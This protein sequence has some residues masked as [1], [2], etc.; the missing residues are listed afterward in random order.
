MR[1]IGLFVGLCLVVSTG[2][3]AAEEPEKT[4]SALLDAITKGT[5][6]LNL[7]Y[8]FEDVDQDGFDQRGKASTLR[9]MA[10]YN[11]GTWKG[12]EI[13][14]E[15]EDVH[16]LGLS[17]DH[18]NA[19]AG[20]LW[21]GV[22]DR[23]VIPDPAITEINQAYLG[24]SPVNTLPLRFGLQEIVV[25]NSRFIGNVG[26]RQNHQ[27]FE[28]ARAAFNGV[29]NLKLDF[30]YIGRQHNIFGGSQPMDTMHLGAAYT[31]GAIGT[32]KAYW[33]ILDYDREQLQALNN[34][35]IGAFFD[36]N[37]KLGKKLKLGYRLEY[38]KQSD[39]NNPN[40]IDADYIRADL[41]LTVSKVVF[42]LGYEALSGSEQDGQFKTPLATLH[43]FN[44]WADKF[45]NTPTNGLQDLFASVTA[46]LGKFKLEGIYHDFSAD[47]GGGD[48]GTEIDAAVIYT[49]PWKQQF[50]IKYADYN[51]NDFATDTTK[52]WIWTSWGF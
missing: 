52:L 5:F 48:W 51:A 40:D 18:N 12:L 22:N 38:A 16:D 42:G 8:R 31:F 4:E 6:K 1:Y 39:V 44:G 11:T 19:G 33:M 3:F 32:L 46:T 43:K 20:S 29:K 17:R 23:P 26:W 2:A 50:A 10:G 24:W 41:G 9:T 15:F 37:A 27:S 7:R 21:N 45:L 14:V 34:A 25:D 28:A 13:Y 49:A 30:S 36:G 47:T 35:T